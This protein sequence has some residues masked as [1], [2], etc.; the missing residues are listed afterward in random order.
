MTTKINVEALTLKLNKAG[1]KS[2]SKPHNTFNENNVIDGSL[3]FNPIHQSLLVH[4]CD[5]V[6]KTNT[7]NSVSLEPSISINILLEGK[8]NYQLGNKHY[9]FSVINNTPLVIVNILNK[10]ELF[11]RFINEDCKVKKVNISC[12]KQWLFERCKTPEDT[13]FLNNLFSEASRVL[14]WPVTQKVNKLANSL[15]EQKKEDSFLNNLLIEKVALEIL[16]YSI[17]KIVRDNKTKNTLQSKQYNGINKD[18]FF[19]KIDILLENNFS[20]SDIAKELAMS[21]STL[22]R[23]FKQNYNVTVIEYFRQKKLNKAREHLL[24][25]GLSIGEAAYIAGYNHASNFN[26]AFKQQFNLTPVEF[27]EHHKR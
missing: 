10:H 18:D 25:D 26:Y 16:A 17:K 19:D 20:L 13:L 7:Y 23:K 6:E 22:Q 8:I 11:T 27:I 12:D 2:R 21:V 15:I 1:I 3:S 24:I 5:I 4:T 14:H 9:E